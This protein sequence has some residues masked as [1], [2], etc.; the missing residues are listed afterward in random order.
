M[1]VATPGIARPCPAV[2][3]GSVLSRR[4]SPPAACDFPARV[5]STVHV[6]WSNSDD[7]WLRLGRFAWAEA[8]SLIPTSEEYKWLTAE[9]A[10]SPTSVSPALIPFSLENSPA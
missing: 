5:G 10:S 8:S 4:K 9:V 6:N 3:R 1:I 2:G 7:A